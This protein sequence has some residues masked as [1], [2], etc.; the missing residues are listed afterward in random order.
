MVSLSR[1]QAYGA[2]STAVFASTVINAFRQRSNFYAAA[3]YLSKSNACMMILWNQAIYQ[4][5]LF[6]KLLQLIFLGELRLIEVERLRERGWFAVTETLLALTIFKDEFE[7]SFV[8][9]FVSLLF[10]KVFHWLSSDRIEAME[11][12]ANVPRL[13]HA[14]MIGLLSSLWVADV[15][16]LLFAADC[17]LVE[18]PTV[19][20]MFA[21]E[22]MILV[23]S[24]WATSMKYVITCIDM[25]REVQWEEKSIYI[26]YVDLIADFFKLVTYLTFFG[27]TLTFYGLPLNI[28]RDVYLTLRSFLLRIRDLR[29]YRLATKN[30]ETLY[31]DAT[32][33]EMEQMSDKTCIICREDMEFQ[34][35]ATQGPAEAEG[36]AT[37][38]QGVDQPPPPVPTT[39]RRGPNE[40][41]KKLPCGHVFHFHC[42]KSW[43]ERQQ[44][45]PTCRRPVLPPEQNGPNPAGRRQAPLRDEELDEYERAPVDPNHQA[46]ALLDA[47]IN[48]ARRLGREAFGQMFPGAPFPEEEAVPEAPRVE[49]TPPQ[50]APAAPRARSSS[51]SR[52]QPATGTRPTPA[53]FGARPGVG[54][55]GALPLVGA[56]RTSRDAPARSLLR[57]PMPSTSA[58]PINDR[59][60]LAH[61]TLPDLELPASGEAGLYH[62]PPT[63]GNVDFDFSALARSS[64]STS[65]QGYAD[66]A[67]GAFPRFGGEVR[68]VPLPQGHG[69]GADR[70]NPLNL[71]QRI[72]RLQRTTG[73]APVGHSRAEDAAA[74]PDGGDTKAKEK[75]K[76]KAAEPQAGEPD[77]KAWD[78]VMQ[79]GE[80][81]VP[82]PTQRQAALLA[83]EKRRAAETGRSGSP[84][85]WARKTD[86][87]AP[88]SEAAYT[89]PL[90]PSREPSP[91]PPISRASTS[92][93]PRRDL[94]AAPSSTAA[95]SAASLPRLYPLFDPSNP[96]V[97]SLY[98]SLAAQPS[99]EETASPRGTATQAQQGEV[100]E[101]VRRAIE[102]KLS[103]LV[104]FQ[105]RIE[106][107]VDEMRTA[108]GS[109]K[110]V[111][112]PKAE[113][114]A[115][116]RSQDQPFNDD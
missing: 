100:D 21:S 5:V 95:R 23:A 38:G 14:R 88:W 2:I 72:Q 109:S 90:P 32:R 68:N 113:L 28:L 110:P 84:A 54:S 56:P 7:S 51:P 19:M 42:L 89:T 46:Q 6:G 67:Y 78:A 85:S 36:Q 52:L 70:P 40:T 116:S 96:S 12:S 76:A 87:L 10:L 104:D 22:Y 108:L 107:L 43:L 60:P 61:F 47:Q 80:K 1:M 73:H 29:R 102:E 93:P 74:Q 50:T 91:T 62:A 25:R 115:S 26:F 69:L 53:S 111:S 71:E 17:I 8:V 44:S 27:L 105:D 31:P 11:Q 3:V 112:N 58:T 59:N 18:G 63:F 37:N 16:M 79:E 92:S 98:P 101:L 35:S 114:P 33:Q 66:L 30:M 24:V 103:V 13:A 82:A 86:S 49:N 15:A 77:W 97:G 20:I 99:S 39:P 45:C 9:L 64:A 81:S 41:P 55:S 94:T 65:Q 83:A 4:T 34:L 75:G 48:L 57:P 106:G